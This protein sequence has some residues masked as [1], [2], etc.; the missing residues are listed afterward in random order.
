MLIK[1]INRQ[2]AI[3]KKFIRDNEV[4]Y[5]TKALR[6]AVMKKSKL[7]KPAKPRQF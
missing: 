5:M 3:K 1:T 4:S 7:E 6:K 2:A